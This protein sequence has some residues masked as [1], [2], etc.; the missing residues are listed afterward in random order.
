MR[1]SRIWKRS[2]ITALGISTTEQRHTFLLR[3]EGSVN[4][5]LG[6]QNEKKAKVHLK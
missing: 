6:I 1:M 2:E 5:F 4:A 3:D